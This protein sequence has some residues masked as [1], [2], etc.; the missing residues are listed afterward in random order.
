M[1]EQ[2]TA[3]TGTFVF[4]LATA[5]LAGLVIGW[6]ARDQTVPEPAALPLASMLSEP[7]A[8]VAPPNPAA[9]A[10]AESDLL[11]QYEIINL[12]FVDQLR[13]YGTRLTQIADVAEA[14]GA[15]SAAQAMRD[16][17]R[18]TDDVISRFDKVSK[19]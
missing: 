19:Q 10:A 5:A 16:F 9:I 2:K 11:R 1:A 13:K 15:A 8:E 17:A 18:E 14:E 4:A 7:A 6:I 3:S 12:G